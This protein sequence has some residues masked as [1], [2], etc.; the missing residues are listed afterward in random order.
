MKLS[1]KQFSLQALNTKDPAEVGRTEGSE[2]LFC[3]R[4][5]S[6]WLCSL[7]VRE[8]LKKK[9]YFSTN[10]TYWLWRWLPHRLSKRQ[11]LTTVLLLRTPITQMIFFTQGI[12]LLGSNHFLITI[13]VQNI[14]TVIISVTHVNFD[15]LPS[16][17]LISWWGSRWYGC[18][19]SMKPF[20]RWGDSFVVLELQ[21]GP[22]DLSS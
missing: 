17:S 22:L 11:S 1:T 6:G 18:D 7:R 15:S 13:S 8:N 4:R 3:H 20:P 12:L 16:L 2:L 21:Y 19:T 14:R 9:K 5:Y 10:T